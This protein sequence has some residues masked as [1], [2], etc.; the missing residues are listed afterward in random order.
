MDRNFDRTLAALGGAGLGAGLL[1]LLDRQAG[2]RRRARLRDKAAHAV[3]QAGDALGMVAAD[4]AGRSHGIR[5]RIRHALVHE[6]VD[7]RV[8]VERVRARLGRYVSHPRSVG[9]I[10]QGGK[11]TLTGPIIARE[12]PGLLGSVRRVPGV[13]EVENA[14]T[15]HDK[16]AGVPGLQGGGIRKGARFE[17]LQV[18]WSPAVRFAAAGAGFWLLA[19]GAARGGPRGW[20]AALT[21]MG[22]LSRAWYN[23]PLSRILGIGYGP[24]AVRLQKTINIDAPPDL[25]FRIFASYDNFPLFMPHVQEVRDL[26]EG[27]SHWKVKAVPGATVEWDAEITELIADRSLGWTSLPGSAVPNAGIIHFSPNPRGGTTVDIKLGYHPPAGEVGHAFARLLGADPKSRL[28][29]DLVAMKDFIERHAAATAGNGSGA[30]AAGGAPARPEG[31]T[32]GP[33]WDG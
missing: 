9:V 25:V 10:A 28:D 6:R 27:R 17:L 24:A 3:K 14:L 29:Q 31:S 18:S 1:Y 12:A 33:A 19:G 5:P 30:P 11:V 13:R 15:L 8:L 16:P 2:A 32:D 21:G 4:V 23:E 7:D 22:L 20:M 26:G